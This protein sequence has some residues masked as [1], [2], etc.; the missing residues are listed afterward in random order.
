VSASVNPTYTLGLKKRGANG[1]RAEGNRPQTTSHD[2][3]TSP[4]ASA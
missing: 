4:S 3:L 1:E 2:Q